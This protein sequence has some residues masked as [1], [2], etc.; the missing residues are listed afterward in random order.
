MVKGGRAPVTGGSTNHP[1]YEIA[2]D[3]ITLS[4]EGNNLDSQ[5]DDAVRNDGCIQQEIRGVSS[6]FRLRIFERKAEI[7]SELR[8][9]FII[10]FEEFI[11]WYFLFKYILLIMLLQLS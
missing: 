8:C 4:N 6:A 5:V 2:S 3:L 9:D 10:V 11:S 7:G 1:N